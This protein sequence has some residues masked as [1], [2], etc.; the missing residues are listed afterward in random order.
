MEEF[1]DQGSVEKTNDRTKELMISK[2]DYAYGEKRLSEETRQQC[3][4]AITGRNFSGYC[5]FKKNTTVWPTSSQYLKNDLTLQYCTPAWLDDTLVVR[6]GNEEEH[7]KKL[8]DVLRKIE[9]ARYRAS[10]EKSEIFQNKLKWLGHEIDENGMKP[11]N[12]PEPNKKTRTIES[13]FQIVWTVFKKFEIFIKRS[14]EKNKK[15]TRLHK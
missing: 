11:N 6:R 12:K 8:V 4:F 2:I 5:L 14:G 7:E 1:L 10:E 9:C 13:F 15:T 3:V